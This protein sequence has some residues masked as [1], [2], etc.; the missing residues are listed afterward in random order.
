MSKTVLGENELAFPRVGISDI[1]VVIPKNYINVREIADAR[2]MSA[3]YAE[4]GLKVRQARI[5]YSETI[6]D[7]A[8]RAI[9]KIKGYEKVERFYLAT[10]S[11]PDLSKPVAITIINGIL[12]LT[13]VPI[14]NKIACLAGLQA[15]RMAFEYSRVHGK[16]CIVI[17]VDRSIYRSI[18]PEA[19]VTIGCAAIAILIETN[20]KLM[21]F[22]N[23]KVGEFA[24]DIDDFKVPIKTAPFPLIDGELSKTAFLWCIKQ[25]LQ[26]WKSKNPTYG[27]I[28]EKMAYI[29][30]HC[31]FPKISEWA[32]ATF[33]HYECGEEDISLDDCIKDITLYP[34]YKEVMD[35]IRK[36]SEEFKEWYK[37]RIEPGLKYNNMIG[38]C[39]PGSLF[40]SLIA[41]LEQIQEGE[42]IGIMGYGSGAASIAIRGIAVS[43]GFQS[44][45]WKQ[46][47][48]GEEIHFKEYEEWKKRTWKETRGDLSDILDLWREVLG[49]EELVE[50]LVGALMNAFKELNPE[51]SK[52]LLVRFL[53]ELQGIT[54]PEVLKEVLETS[55]VKISKNRKKEKV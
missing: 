23:Q 11:D 29:I 34:K 24:K 55:L 45:L 28:I 15:M 38:N 42:E 14:Q 33:W 9:Q 27:S 19:E 7:L 6:K 35:K 54:S 4:K 43:S 44:D 50:P 2:G 22:D 10:E 30:F 46:I 26:D 13:T 37:K 16:Q 32:A 47:E 18:N 40:I 53:G 1:T 3:G 49:S 31:P 51:E 52:K 39:Y 20:P 8:A 25:A 48:Q 36:F 41:V 21:A 17:I 12:G 5:P